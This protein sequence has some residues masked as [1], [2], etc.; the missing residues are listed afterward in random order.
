[1]SAQGNA[2]A[3]IR[4]EHASQLVFDQLELVL[5]SMRASLWVR[6]VIGIALAFSYS[7]GIVSPK[8]AIWLALV[9]AASTLSALTARSFL[10][11]SASAARSATQWQRLYCL[12]YIPFALV[13]TSQAYFLWKP[14]NIVNHCMILLTLGCSVSVTI[15][16]LGACLPLALTAFAIIGSG[17]LGVAFVTGTPGHQTL[18]LVVLVYLAL[19]FSILRQVHAAATN[20]LLLR[21][22]NSDLLAEQGRLICEL[23]G[24]RQVAEQKCLEAEKANQSKSQFLA[25]MSHELRTP[26]N[27][28][29]GFSEIIRGRILGDDINRNIEYAGLIHRSGTH[30]LT[31]INDILDLAKIEAGS[32]MLVEREV[33]LDILIAEAVALLQ[34]RAQQGGC[35]LIAA[36]EP[37]LPRVRADERALNQVL[38][39]LL[40]NALKFTL[41][42][43]TVTAFAHPMADGRV[44]FGVSDTGVG[45]APEDQAKVFEKFG[46]GRHTHIPKETG[47]GLGLSIVRGLIDAHGGQIGLESVEHEGTTVTVTLPSYRTMLAQ[48]Q[49]QRLAAKA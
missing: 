33:A 39:N 35:T 10:T 25:N 28:I 40:S 44:A 23:A 29:L 18:A 41:S 13:W 36:V 24:A 9:I 48:P 30:L 15:P 11:R 21:Y 3:V 49:I 8:P 22:E 19:L 1:M 37:G 5:R 17:F 32:F 7:R 31:L 4:S 26:L 14:G 42:G 38:L 45:I 12:S 2:K 20:T 46:Q 6:P 27:A 34:H 47:T 43:G 16:L